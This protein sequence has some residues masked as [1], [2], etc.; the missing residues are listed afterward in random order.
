MSWKL[1]VQ[2]LIMIIIP[3]HFLS[4]LLNAST[5]SSLLMHCS[6]MISCFDNLF[7]N[8]KHTF[9]VSKSF[10]YCFTSG[11]VSGSRLFSL[12]LVNSIYLCFPVSPPSIVSTPRLN[13]TITNIIIALRL[14]VSLGLLSIHHTCL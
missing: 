10:L 13:N 7:C 5:P 14:Y 2:K 11:Q 9:L 1:C 4:S 8:L 6:L 12:L 3:S